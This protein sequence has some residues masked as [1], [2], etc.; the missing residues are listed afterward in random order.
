[1]RLVPVF[2]GCQ[3]ICG[4]TRN[5]HRHSPRV[6]ERATFTLS[7]CLT[8][9]GAPFTGWVLASRI[10]S[11]GHQQ[12]RALQ[13]GEVD[14]FCRRIF[15]PRR[16]HPQSPDLFPLLAAPGK[17]FG[18]WW[19]V[20]T[21]SGLTSGV[22]VRHLLSTVQ[23]HPSDLRT[24]RSSPLLRHRRISLRIHQQGSRLLLRRRHRLPALAARRS[25]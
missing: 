6:G 10:Q 1:M 9:S 14:C 5:P 21:S 11:C 20:L 19:P 4:F 25:C 2:P 13:T 7:Y 17:G 24:S 22:P 23:K 8:L 15:S 3:T 18:C 12:G 16:F